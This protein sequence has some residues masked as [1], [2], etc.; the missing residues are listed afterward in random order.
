MNSA[1]RWICPN[2]K[3]YRKLPAAN[4]SYEKFLFDLVEKVKRGLEG[5]REV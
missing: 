5:F 4:L 1:S 2:E 3:G